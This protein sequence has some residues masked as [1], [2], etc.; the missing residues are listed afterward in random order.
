MVHV[1]P[2]GGW[3]H[4]PIHPDRWADQ[5]LKAWK[6][7]T[8][9]KEVGVA[10]RDLSLVEIDQA[11]PGE[12]V[13]TPRSLQACILLGVD[14]SEIQYRPFE[15]FTERGLSREFQGIKYEFYEKARK[16]KILQLLKERERI[17]SECDTGKIFIKDGKIVEKGPKGEF[18]KPSESATKALKAAEVAQRRVEK[19]RQKKMELDAI[20]KRMQEDA[21]RVAALLSKKEYEQR[22]EKRRKEKEFAAQQAAIAAKKLAEELATEKAAIALAKENYA[23]ELKL[24]QERAIAAENARK[25]AMAA[26]KERAEKQLAFQKELEKMREKMLQEA[27]QKR[28]KLEAKDRKLLQIRALKEEKIKKMN[29]IAHAEA[30]KRQTAALQAYY[31]MLQKKRDDFN[32]KNEAVAIQQAEKQA[33]L[34][35]ILQEKLMMQE[36]A[37][38]DRQRTM[39]LAYEQRKKRIEKIVAKA[40][41][42][43]KLLREFLMR[44]RHDRVK[45]NVVNHLEYSKAQ[46]LVN[47]T[48]R[49]QALQRKHLLTYIEEQTKKIQ[50]L[51]ATRMKI[52]KQRQLSEAKMMWAQGKG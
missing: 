9:H 16:E 11:K 43:A 18:P 39:E 28:K 1:A 41:H 4:D 27:I 35:K 38:K 13:N 8:Y 42:K 36:K 51:M 20:A 3:T 47:Q 17:I 48:A 33:E 14:P 15:Y 23:H 37:N 12:L 50:D 29:A 2:P 21:A 44:S 46:I 31:N 10:K 26:A 30:K 45:K 19:E 49:R 5:M 6:V 22:A 32:A 7:A 34:N 40:N 25:M 24:Q 52:Q